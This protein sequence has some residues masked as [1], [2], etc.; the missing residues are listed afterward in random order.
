MVPYGEA[1]AYQKR[2]H[3][4]VVAGN[5]PPA[6]LRLGQPRVSTLGR[7]ARGG[8]RLFPES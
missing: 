4:E 7:K 1:W 2:V 5:R 6:L 3:R 8:D